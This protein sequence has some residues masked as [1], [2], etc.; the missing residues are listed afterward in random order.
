MLT[1]LAHI[2]KRALLLLFLVVASSAFGQITSTQLKQ[3]I[4]IDSV[5]MF[6]DLAFQAAKDNNASERQ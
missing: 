6:R 2:K 3:E 4:Q 5:L 1:V